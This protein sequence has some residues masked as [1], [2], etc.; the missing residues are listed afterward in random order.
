LRSGAA[1]LQRR[2]G[3]EIGPGIGSVR[4]RSGEWTTVEVVAD[5]ERDYEKGPG[6][7]CPFCF[8]GGC[9]YNLGNVE[10]EMLN[11]FGVDER[12]VAR[13]MKRGGMLVK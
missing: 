12:S 2:S 10:I 3:A 9:I 13:V 5:Q 8:C 11:G 6:V 7:I 4:S 1:A